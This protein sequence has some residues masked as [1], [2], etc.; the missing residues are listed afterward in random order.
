M[1][2]VKWGIIGVGDVTE[3]KSGPAFNLVENSEIIS[4]MR[5]TLNK[6]EDYAR[7]HGIN[8]YTNDANTLLNDEEIN[9]VYIATPP[10]SHAEYAIR[11]AEAGKH[12][13]VEKPMALNYSECNAMIDAA[14][15][16][17][18]KLFV[19]Y[20]RRELEYF[21]KVKSLIENDAIGEIRSVQIKFLAHPNKNDYDPDNLPW[22]V[23]P[24]IA[25]AGYF[26]D[27][28]SHQL[29]FLD[30]LL[31][32][33]KS[34]KGHKTNQLSLYDAEDTV[35]ASL[36]FDSNVLGSGL[37]S[38]TVEQ[39]KEVDSTLIIGNSGSIEFSFFTPNPIK[40]E[41]NKGREEISIP[42]PKHV[43]FQL[44]E[45]VV[46]DILGKGKCVS[47]GISASRTNWVMEEILKE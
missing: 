37:W 45:S 24:D 2:K 30:Y 11:A 41:T 32:P 39:G 3:V 16:N 20:Y 14:E 13:Y 26:Y 1:N 21:K 34:A 29:D 8:G 12:I 23:K 42:Y 4:V 7:R 40:I 31:G 46:K 18:V 25:G 27:L 38:F 5:R 35:S 6:A 47:T 15:N 36:L 10:S 22:R 43:Q 33:V 44:I 28:A 9:A 17:G 19:A